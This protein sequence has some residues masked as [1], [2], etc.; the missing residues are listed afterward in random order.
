[1]KQKKWAKVLYLYSAD[2]FPKG[3]M[4]EL[5]T[6]AEVETA[7]KDYKL[8]SA[9]NYII[10]FNEV[11]N[12]SNSKRLQSQVAFSKKFPIIKDPQTAIN[13]LR[14]VSD[15]K[16]LSIPV[17]EI[18][19]SILKDA[20]YNTGKGIVSDK[21]YDAIEDRLRKLHPK[22]KVLTTG[23]A[24]RERKIALPFYMGSMDK[25]TDRVDAWKQKGPYVVTDKLDGVSALYC[26]LDG[27]SKLYTRGDGK[28]G[29]D[30]SHILKY[31]KLPKIKRG[32]AVRGEMLLSKSDYKEIKDAANP[33]NYVSGLVSRKSFSKSNIRFVAYE[34]LSP[35][36]KVS[37]AIKF[38]E[39]ASI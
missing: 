18:I 30:I 38:L 23:I 32:T 36:M 1:M 14:K 19:V 2:L 6:V 9:S 4:A 17:L 10:T 8:K 39:E 24:P 37:K 28:Q 29:Q 11:K 31:M 21:K 3:K 34:V 7:I 35:R 22:S 26:N 12:T 16:K 20:Y 5:K 25:I 13:G 33:R 27:T 15:L